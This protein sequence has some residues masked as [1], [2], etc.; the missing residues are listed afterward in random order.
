MKNIC[1]LIILTLSVSCC[2]LFAEQTNGNPVVSPYA[3][4]LVVLRGEK[5]APFNADKFLQAPFIVLYYGASWCPD[6][7][8]FS[9]SLVTAYDQ[10]PA[11]NKRFGV[12]LVSQDQSEEGMLKFMKT[13]KMTWPAVAF[14]KLSDAKTL[15]ELYSGHGIPCLTVLDRRGKVVLQSKTDQDAESV[16]TELLDISKR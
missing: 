9:P 15:Q 16:L 8:R 3:D 11:D 12:L 14:S 7:R 13:E 1:F 5:L 10:Q 6:C 2:G 4:S